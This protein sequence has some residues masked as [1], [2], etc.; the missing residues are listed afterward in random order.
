MRPLKLSMTAFGPYANKQ[1]IDFRLLNDKSFF[2]IHGP[3]GAGKTTILD[4]ICFA[5]YGESSGNTRTSEHMRSHHSK[6]STA[7]EVSFDFM[8]GQEIYRVTRSLKRGPNQYGNSEVTYKTDKAGLWQRTDIKNDQELGTLLASKWTKVTEAIETL[9][10]FESKQFRQVILLPQDQFQKLL[11][12]SSQAREDL[13]KVLFQTEQFEAVENA[14][15]EEAKYIMDELSDLRSKRKFILDMAQVSKPD[16]L[17]EKQKKLELELQNID[18]EIQLLRFKEQEVSQSLE[19]GKDN[20]RKIDERDQAK[21]RLETTTLKKAELDVKR[22]YLTRAQRAAELIDL[23]KVAEQQLDDANRLR[24]QQKETETTLATVQAVQ[25]EASV[26]LTYEMQRGQERIAAY[27]DRDYLESLMGQVQE[28]EDSRAKLI[29]EIE[30]VEQVTDKLHRAEARR[31]KLQNDL[32]QL[33]QSLRTR[34][35]VTGFM[36]SAQ[37][38]EIDTRLAYERWYKLDEI[39]DQWEQ[40]QGK[41]AEVQKY[42]QQIEN[43]L[44]L[45]LESRNELEKA[46]HSSQASVL[47]SGLIDG[48]PCPVCGSINHPKSAISNEI[49]IT[50]AELQKAREVVA[51]LESQKQAVQSEWLLLHENTVRLDADRISQAQL[52]GTKANLK[53]HQINDEL[54]KV[55]DALQKAQNED[56]QLNMLQQ[57]LQPLKEQLKQTQSEFDA[58]HN[59]LQHALHQKA[60]VQAVFSER[61][62]NIPPEL[63]DQ[64]IV[65]RALKDARDKVVQLDQAIAQAQ[66]VEQQAN[67][68]VVRLEATLKQITEQAVL[69]EQRA[70][71]LNKQFLERISNADFQNIQDY[72]DSKL[73]AAEI[74]LLD[75]DI[76]DFDALLQSAQERGL[77]WRN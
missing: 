65:T 17:A 1:D 47:A 49:K 72:V 19:Q 3:T 54:K 9:F 6:I 62:R 77:I 71:A 37:Q 22:K 56:K 76:R 55:Q 18:S 60:T 20:Q 33:E 29:V 68:D 23:E 42:Y 70:E 32:E 59:E 35:I 34:E 58:W 10:G 7:T 61:E 11:M 12:A 67:E 44:H 24:Q 66:K 43:D 45:A 4:A 40:A 27:H 25:Q 53:S 75:Q 31:D 63:S 64:Q 15:K 14:L 38:S 48:E 28:L 69:S 46:W 2:L 16:E 26:A 73:N 50:E 5:L 39:R 52:L 51:D 41:E 13:F 21:A 74:A 30:Q 57:Q 8:L 36:I